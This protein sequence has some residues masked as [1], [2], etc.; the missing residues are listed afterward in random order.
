MGEYIPL[1]SL[2]IDGEFNNLY[3]FYLKFFNIFLNKA[4]NWFKWDFY[5]QEP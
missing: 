5:A 2:N 3:N 1:I 4:Y